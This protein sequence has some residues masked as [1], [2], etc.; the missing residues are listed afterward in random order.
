M[1]SRIEEALTKYIA[2]HVVQMGLAI[3][4]E[5]VARRSVFLGRKLDVCAPIRPLADYWW[6]Q[7]NSLARLTPY[8]RFTR[9]S[10]STG[11]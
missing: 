7:S 3:E 9:P 5:E 6:L 8:F 10:M 11:R 2:E 1:A 4:E